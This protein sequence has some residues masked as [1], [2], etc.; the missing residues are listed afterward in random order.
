MSNNLEKLVSL[1]LVAAALLLLSPLQTQE[2]IIAFGQGHFLACYYY[3]YKYGKMN[4]AYLM[5]YLGALVLV[6]GGYI[7]YPN[8]YLLVTAAS[9]YFVVHLSVDERFLWKEQP[10]LQRGLAFLPFLLIYMGM[11]VDSIFV[12]HVRIETG[13]TAPMEFPVSILGIWIT[14]YCVVAAGIALVAYLAFIRFKPSR[15]E[16]HDVYFL[17][18]AAI[19]ALL[20]VTNHVPNH[21]YLMGA[22]ILFHYS[23][24]YVHY[25]RRFQENRPLRNRYLLDMLVIYA[26][27]FAL[28]GFYRAMPR[29]LNVE[30]FPS[31]IFPYKTQNHGNV[32]AYL[33]S[34]G[35]FYL[36]TFMHYLTTLRLSD[37]GY[38]RS[39]ERN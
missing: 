29:A 24:W 3:Q 15:M 8:L 5:K 38:F 1:G 31:Q 27:I 39:R 17:L 28:Y 16:T 33:F 12:G 25:Y 19:L 11:I 13:Y 18:G 9:V 10:S 34:P 7:L 2:A 37:L 14:P 32:L 30:Y 4:R 35:F 20:Y 26:I 6:F 21:F 36:W 23:S 22:I